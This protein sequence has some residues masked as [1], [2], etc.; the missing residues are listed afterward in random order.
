MHEEALK[1]HYDIENL[2]ATYETLPE[3]EAFLRSL[4]FVLSPKYRLTPLERLGSLKL[5]RV[6]KLKKKRKVVAKTSVEY[7]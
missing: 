2:T 3:Q 6:S 5:G 7:S 4:S 1:E